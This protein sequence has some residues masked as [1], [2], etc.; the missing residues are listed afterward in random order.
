MNSTDINCRSIGFTNCSHAHHFIQQTSST[1]FTR[2]HYLAMATYNKIAISRTTAASKSLHNHNQSIHLLQKII[3]L[4]QLQSMFASALVRQSMF[5]FFL[6]CL[7]CNVA[8]KSS[9]LQSK[10]V[11]KCFKVIHVVVW[12]IFPV[13]VV[14][15]ILANL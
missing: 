15:R 2:T 5:F 1:S 9:S 7:S 11:P 3:H 6:Y 8:S 10:V 12:T 13:I 4:L 14:T